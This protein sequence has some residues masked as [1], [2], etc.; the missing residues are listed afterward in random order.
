MKNRILYTLSGLG[1]I[2]AVL[3]VSFKVYTEAGWATGI[4][5]FLL[6]LSTFWLLQKVNEILE[7][8]I[9]AL[10]IVM[11]VRQKDLNKS[12]KLLK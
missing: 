9:R 2:L 11:E 3:V 6:I 1:F 5:T 12:F 4:V 7:I 10:E 8:A